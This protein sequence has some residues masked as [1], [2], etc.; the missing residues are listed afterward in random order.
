MYRNIIRFLP[1][2]MVLLSACGGNVTPATEAVP[3]WTPDPCT[4]TSLNASIKPINDLQREFDDASGLASNL[5]VEQLDEAISNLQRIR[6]EAEDIT[7][8]PCLV[9]LKSYQLAHMNAVIDTMVAFIGGADSATLNKGLEL[10]RQ[11]HD[12][13]TIEMA[14]VLGVTLIPATAAP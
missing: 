12:R 14:R 4:I 5:P 10:A 9:A 7:P 3:T 11:E 2:F 8:P 13:Y 1:M 6:R